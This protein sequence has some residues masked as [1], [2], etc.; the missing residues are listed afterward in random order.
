MGIL[1]VYISYL[2]FYA[3]NKCSRTSRSVDISF[4][5]RPD[6]EQQHQN[7]RNTRKQYS[8][9]NQNRMWHMDHLPD[10]AAPYHPSAAS[11]PHH[12]RFHKHL[13]PEYQHHCRDRNQ[14]ISILFYR[15]SVYF[16]I[17]DGKTVSIIFLII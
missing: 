17:V 12:H 10:R 16:R 3:K 15:I 9:H 11:D 6:L 5:L 1:V 7:L 13:Y 8:Y 2:T 14:L 4:L